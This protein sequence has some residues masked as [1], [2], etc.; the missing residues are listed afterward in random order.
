MPILV[1]V[2]AGF[3]VTVGAEARASSDVTVIVIE[4]VGSVRPMVRVGAVL[5][6]VTVIFPEVPVLEA[7]SEAVASMVFAPAVEVTLVL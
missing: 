3:T 5:S 7:L 2:T 4:S 6:K 1:I